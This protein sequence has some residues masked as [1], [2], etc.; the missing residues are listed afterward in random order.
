LETFEF[1]LPS[2]LEANEP[3]E[4]RGLDRDEV[5]LM[6]SCREDDH[7]YHSQFRDLPEYLSPGDLL[8]VNASGTRNSAVAVTRSG[9]DA[10]FVMH[11]S[12]HLP[13]GKWVVELRLPEGEKTKPFY[14]AQS[15]MKFVLPKGGSANLLEPY[16]LGDR[17]SPDRVH[18]W[19]ADLSLPED[20]ASYLAQ[21]GFPIR[22]GYVKRMWPGSYYQTV[23]ATEVGSAEMP[24]A[25]RAFTP[26]LLDR[27][28]EADIEIVPLIL[29]C[30]IA[31]LEDDEEPLEE[32]YRVPAETAEA[33]N[34]A[35]SEGKRVIA[36]GTTVIRALESTADSDGTVHPG[37][38][39]TRLVVSPERGGIRTVD[40]LI[41]GF[42]EPHSTHLAMLQSVAPTDHVLLAYAEALEERYLWHEFGDLHLIMTCD[43]DLTQ[44]SAA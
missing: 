6:V 8:V 37:E 40:G 2:E 24:S 44:S 21:V 15:G 34:M 41:T 43:D 1:E 16:T 28:E 31:S 39:W 26:S 11:L 7:I 20:P 35:R 36:V 23:Y 12:T 13:S 14:E 9:D 29:H 32:F 42:H 5:R 25:G 17:I 10:P 19:Q 27:L 38:G 4:A 18:L 3:P 22:Y 33:V 30:G